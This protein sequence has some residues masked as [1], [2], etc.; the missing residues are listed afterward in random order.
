MTES[1]KK[2]LDKVQEAFAKGVESESEE[3]EGAVQKEGN[4]I[5]RVYY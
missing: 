5:A 3:E 1:N 4:T 2:L